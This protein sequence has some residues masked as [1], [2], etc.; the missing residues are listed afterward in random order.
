MQNETLP[1]V[2]VEG[3]D[4]MSLQFKNNLMEETAA[5]SDSLT[6][7]QLKIQMVNMECNSALS[8]TK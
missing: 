6:A 8:S 2:I 7:L 4:T 5:V 1:E 3:A